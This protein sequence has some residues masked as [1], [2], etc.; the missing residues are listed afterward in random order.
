MWCTRLAGVAVLTVAAVT[1]VVAAPKGSKDTELQGLQRQVEALEAQVKA[2]DGQLK[3]MEARMRAAETRSAQAVAA[4][5]GAAQEPE[6][7]ALLDEAR[8][9]AREGNT[10]A[11]KAKLN[12]L[13]SK[14]GSS[15]AAAQARN[16]T[17]ELAVVGKDVPKDWGIDQWF[18]G[19]K[20]IDLSGKKTTLVVFWEE[21]CPHCKREVPK[22]QQLYTD[23]KAQGL[24]VLGLTKMSKGVTEEKLK[25][26]MADNKVLY[27]TAKEDGSMSTYFNVSGVPAAAVIRD[28]KV[29]WRGHPAQLSD[30]TLKGWL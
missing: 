26:F 15:R 25:S 24:Q 4:P 14:H 13:Q 6:A 11:A 16:F 10:D 17:N 20:E 9:L 23:H 21:W 1:A 19:E 3:A 18:Q 2:L 22:L 29:V 27:P 28:G 8:K 5:G 12:E 30:E 7:T